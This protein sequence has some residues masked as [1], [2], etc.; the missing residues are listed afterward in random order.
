MGPVTIGERFVANGCS[1]VISSNYDTCGTVT[2]STMSHL[3]ASQLNSLFA[4]GGLFADLDA[5]FKYSVEMNACGVRRFALYDWIMSNADRE[6]YRGA[7]SGTKAVGSPSLVHPFIFGRQ[8]SVVNRDHFKVTNGFTGAAYGDLNN[9]AGNDFYPLS[10][11]QLALATVPALLETRVIRIESRHGIPMDANW[12]RQHETI[13]IF[14]R[15]A[16]GSYL[17]GQWKVIATA[18]NSAKTFIDVFAADLNGASVEAYNQAPTTGVVIPGVNNVNDY[19]KW[20]QN[21]PTIDPRKRVPFW[22]QTYRTGRCI[23]SEYRKVYARLLESNEAFRQFGDLDSAERNRQDELEMKKRFVN[24]FFFNKPLPSQTLN[25]WESLE[26]IQST[27][28]AILDPGLGGKLMTRRANFVGV[29]EQLRQCDRVWDL[30]N[31]PLNLY[32]FLNLNYD[33]MRARESSTL[34][35]SRRKVT[36]IDWWTDST[37]RAQFQT[38]AFQYYKDE[39]L[40]QLRMTVQIN[41]LNDSLGIVYDSYHFKRP[42]NVRI[43]IMSDEYFDDFRIE[44]ADS[45][46]ESAGTRLWSLDLGKKG[47]GSIYWAHIASNRKVYTTAEIEQL[48][49]FDSTYRCVMAVPS[50]EQTLLSNTG[51]AVVDCPLNSAVL[52]NIKNQ[53]PITT[54]ITAGST[55]YSYSDLY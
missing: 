16:G 9:T 48:A 47:S 7:V 6:A 27:A 31:N 19:E 52:G 44:M 50:I 23:D 3:T 34:T 17:H 53:T 13:H 38:A 28:G 14:G 45:G 41:Q 35:G 20:C 22:V 55:T 32:E 43:N 8:E 10:D 21:L 5:W 42:G 29:M 39:Y 18:S 36:D 24:E 26:P 30:G 25:G 37:F 1:P 15:S 2:R 54:G 46:F 33:L 11:V 49:K 4:P 51:T 12:F 40:D